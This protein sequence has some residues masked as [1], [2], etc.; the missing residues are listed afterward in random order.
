MH[1]QERARVF[2]HAGISFLLSFG[3]IAVSVLVTLLGVRCD[4]DMQMQR[5]GGTHH[6]GSAR[7]CFRYY[8]MMIPR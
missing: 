3:V 8:M 7:S 4:S 1:A 5:A 2:E 6:C